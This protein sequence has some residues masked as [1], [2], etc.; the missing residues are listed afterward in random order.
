MDKDDCV[1]DEALKRFDR[2]VINE[3]GGV[4]FVKGFF[5][6]QTPPGYPLPHLLAAYLAG[7]TYL[8]ADASPTSA[9]PTSGGVSAQ[10]GTQPEA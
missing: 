4:A 5:G 10:G 3:I 8:P 2:Y 6:R 1:T 7:Q 9:A